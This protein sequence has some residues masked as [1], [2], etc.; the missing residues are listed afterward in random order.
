M[1][2]FQEMVLKD[3]P[4]QINWFDKEGEILILHST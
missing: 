4:V 3:Y 1:A 2:E